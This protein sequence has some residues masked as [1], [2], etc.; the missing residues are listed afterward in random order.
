MLKIKQTANKQ[1]NLVKKIDASDFFAVYLSRDI[2]P[3][4]VRAE[5]MVNR[6]KLHEPPNE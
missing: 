6:G 2:A 1:R 5:V 3:I 4:W